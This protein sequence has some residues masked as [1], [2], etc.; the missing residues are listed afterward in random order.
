[1]IFHSALLNSIPCCQPSPSSELYCQILRS[2]SVLA[3]FCVTSHDIHHFLF[4]VSDINKM[5]QQDQSHTQRSEAQ[6]HQGTAFLVAFLPIQKIPHKKTY[7][8]RIQ[9]LIKRSEKTLTMQVMRHSVAGQKILLL[10]V[11]KSSTV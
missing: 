7:L 2:S 1:M 8:Y 9:S 6:Y 3:M 4:S 10:R 5:F 11:F